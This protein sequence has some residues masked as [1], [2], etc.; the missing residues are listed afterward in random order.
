[1]ATAQKRGEEPEGSLNRRH[2]LKVMAFGG[3]AVGLGLLGWHMKNRITRRLEEAGFYNEAENSFDVTDLVNNASKDRKIDFDEALRGR[4]NPT[5][6]KLWARARAAGWTDEKLN[7]MLV[8]LRAGNE[9]FRK[10]SAA[11]TG[12]EFAFKRYTLSLVP[13]ASWIATYP[14]EKTLVAGINGMPG[15]TPDEF[16]ASVRPLSHHESAH[17]MVHEAQKEANAR[18]GGREPAPG[19]VVET[20]LYNNEAVS[21]MTLNLRVVPQDKFFEYGLGEAIADKLGLRISEHAGLGA[22]YKRANRLLALKIAGMYEGM[23][24]DSLTSQRILLGN[25]TDIAEMKAAAL[26]FGDPG[27][28]DGLEQ[29]KARI[30]AAAA[31]PTTLPNGK[32]SPSLDPQTIT[33]L[34]TDYAAITTLLTNVLNKIEPKKP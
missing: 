18:L 20:R 22:E 27:L 25:V 31:N 16:T 9:D 32:P 14:E 29:S 26:A 4:M 1:M 28:A 15:L 24:K 17:I 3:A 33:E 7:D 19:E 30:V 23:M 34:E 11:L 8:Q 13:R 10:A 21:A 5:K 2:F 12:Q 6:E